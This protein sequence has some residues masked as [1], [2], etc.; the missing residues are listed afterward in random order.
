MQSDGNFVVHS[1]GRNDPAGA[2]WSSNTY[3]TGWQ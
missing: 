1:Q 3:G 2:L